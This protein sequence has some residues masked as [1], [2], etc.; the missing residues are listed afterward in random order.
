M[1][2]LWR[3]PATLLKAVPPLNTTRA[4]DHVLGLPPKLSAP[5]PAPPRLL[6]GVYRGPGELVGAVRSCEGLG[7]LAGV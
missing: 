2:C 3:A 7:E 5:T 6:L 1:G 4:G